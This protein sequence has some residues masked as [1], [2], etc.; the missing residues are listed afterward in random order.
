MENVDQSSR[1]VDE[2][3]LAPV[4]TTG[5]SC[6]DKTLEATISST[7]PEDTPVQLS[8]SADVVGIVIAHEDVQLE[9][10]SPLSP[11]IA[12]TRVTIDDDLLSETDSLMKSVFSSTLTPISSPM[13]SPKDDDD[14]E[15]L[16]RPPSPV[17][18]NPKVLNL[19]LSHAPSTVSERSVIAKGKENV[20][21]DSRNASPEPGP[22]KSRLSSIEPW[23]KSV[24]QEGRR[25]SLKPK[26]SSS[27]VSDNVATADE[28]DSQRNN[29]TDERKKRPREA[30]V[31]ASRPCSPAPSRSGLPP[32][33]PKKKR[34]R[35]T[36]VE[37][38]SCKQLEDSNEDDEASIL[39]PPVLAARSTTPPPSENSSNSDEDRATRLEMGGF[40]IQAMALSRAS[41]MPASSLLREVLREN[42]QLVNKRS[43][44]TWLEL[45]N[46]VLRSSNVYGR[47]DREGMVR[48]I[49][50]HHD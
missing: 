25:A 18:G 6:S 45:V 7:S 20:H 21:F 30:S 37:G 35:K 15:S 19:M 17:L 32:P 1:K 27:T 40:L 48:L 23:G 50:A 34:S 36:E 4:Y 33:K 11:E 43:K 22:S 12:H 49:Y 8:D 13:I 47:I 2:L 46:E 24:G 41:S 14:M 26:K 5:T 9:P 38:A 16:S 42:P 31:G 44:D 10:M 29:A 39:S 28:K 3:V